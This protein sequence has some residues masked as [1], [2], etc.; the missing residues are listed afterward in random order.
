MTASLSGG[1]QAELPATAAALG[2]ALI[3]ARVG[4]CDMAQH[5]ALS[6]SSQVFCWR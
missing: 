3:V 5:R 4:N 6:H 2:L 1:M